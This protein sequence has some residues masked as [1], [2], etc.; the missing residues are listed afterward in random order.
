ML[1]QQLHIMETIV[2]NVLQKTWKLEGCPMCNTWNRQDYISNNNPTCKKISHWN[3]VE[4]FCYT[5]VPP[6]WQLEC[7]QEAY[8]K[9]DSNH[10]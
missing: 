9:Q 4:E 8:G 10:F 6:S 5:K 2:Q 3:Q 7:D 1:K